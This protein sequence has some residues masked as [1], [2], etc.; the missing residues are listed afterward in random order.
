MSSS[1]AAKPAQLAL[2][3]TP[4]AQIHKGLPPGI[5]VAQLASIKACTEFEHRLMELA[6][7]DGTIKQHVLAAPESSGHAYCMLSSNASD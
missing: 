6:K 2:Q 3:V 4:S 1:A 5:L 7:Q